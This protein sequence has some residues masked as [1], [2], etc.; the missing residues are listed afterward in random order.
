MISISRRRP[1]S[2]HR[3]STHHAIRVKFVPVVAA[4]YLAAISAVPAA[5]SEFRGLWV[6]AF[7]PGFLNAEQVKKLVSDCR[8]YNFNAIFVQMRRRGDAFYFPKSPNQDPRTTDLH[9]DFDA[10]AELIEQCHNGTP[11]IQVH[12]WLTS[13]LVWSSPV[14][15]T[16][17]DHI[18]NRHRDWLTRDSDDETL[19]ANG[20]YLDPG[21]PDANQWLRDVALDIVSRYDVDG[22]HWDYLRYPGPDSG[23]NPTALR[24]YNEEFGAKEK[25]AVGDSRFNA[26][27]RRQV[28][29]FLRW[30]TA[31]LLQ[32]KPQLIVSV[33]VFA[34]YS[35]SFGY[36]F[37]EWANW[38]QE[39][40]LDIAIPMNF[41]ADN[42]NV[43]V[44][45]ATRAVANKGTRAVYLGQGAYLN[46]TE[47]TLRQLG[48]CREM[49]FGGTVLYSYRSLVASQAEAETRPAGTVSEVTK[50][51]VVDN[52]AAMAH[53]PWRRGQFSGY[54]GNDYSFI[55]EDHGTNYVQFV[56]KLPVEGAYD[57]YE[58]HVAGDNRATDVPFEIRHN[59]GT[60][61]VK[62]NQ[63]RDG[64]KWNFLGRFNFGTNSSGSVRVTDAIRNANQVVI[65]DGVRFD[66]A[67]DDEKASQPAIDK[68]QSAKSAAKS[69]DA[70]SDREAFLAALKKHHQPEWTEVPPLARKTNPKTGIIKGRVT[71]S[72]SSTP[73]YNAVLNLATKPERT[74]KTEP[75][76]AYAFFEVPPGTYV[77][78]ARAEG[79]AAVTNK[80]N[81]QVGAVVEADLVLTP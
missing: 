13:H 27:R 11:P 71:Q 59:G 52:T 78:I 48:L 69:N 44:P 57:V 20:Y 28:T 1:C 60:N 74:Q 32:I 26:W 10:L 4:I 68:V 50:S 61:V 63:Q 51:I 73:V 43:F 42:G 67:P 29:D 23:Y 38:C 53:G 22:L 77:I 72:Q 36:R 18:Y 39:G 35:D 5:A 33:S 81:V 75:H 16:Q 70:E 8:E 30:T 58:W 9:P 6:D 37:A 24:R 64:S 14:P 80:V 62:V 31:D 76:G 7:G 2:K 12:C 46:T 19:M 55:V 25:P 45:R 3:G 66:P 54:H 56:P 49:G 34:N 21:H 17:P 15:P 79:F 41:T 65:A 40:I 47:N